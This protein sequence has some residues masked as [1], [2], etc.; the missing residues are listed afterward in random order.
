MTGHATV[1]RDQGEI[2]PIRVT[3]ENGLEVLRD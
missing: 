1:T 2:V 3:V